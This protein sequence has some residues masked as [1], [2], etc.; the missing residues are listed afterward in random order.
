MEQSPPPPVDVI[1]PWIG[2]RLSPR[3]SRV[4]LEN[5][6]DALA[7]VLLCCAFLGMSLPP[8]R[9]ATPDRTR[10]PVPLF[11]GFSVSL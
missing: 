11:P 3:L 4:S 1:P 8:F 9:S 5:A 2:P 6:S 7:P 10:G